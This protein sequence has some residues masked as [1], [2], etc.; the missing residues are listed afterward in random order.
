[1]TSRTRLER[2]QVDDVLGGEEMWKHADSIAGKNPANPFF[3]ACHGPR[4]LGWISSAV[5]IPVL[6]RIY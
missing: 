4:P 2:K 3:P 5:V 6:P 1:M